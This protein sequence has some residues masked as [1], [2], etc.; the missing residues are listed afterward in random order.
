MT[1]TRTAF[2]RNAAP[3]VYTFE[4]VLEADLATGIR[5]G[6][7][8]RLIARCWVA[9]GHGAECGLNADDYEQFRA[10]WEKQTFA[11]IH[12]TF[13]HLLP[14]EYRYYK[15]Q[16]FAAPAQPDPAKAERQAA[17]AARRAELR[18]K[19]AKAPERL[20]RACEKKIDFWGTNHP[21]A[22]QWAFI[23]DTARA[24]TEQQL[25][26]LFNDGSRTSG[27]IESKLE[28]QFHALASA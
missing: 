19:F 13:D 21:T 18:A 5:G 20:A 23:R 22:A 24:L 25:D 10:A 6:N 2:P 26:D 9:A 3:V 14:T 28:R 8:Y 1:V 7:K 16:T 15:G 12:A 17:K 27:D 11:K 4:T